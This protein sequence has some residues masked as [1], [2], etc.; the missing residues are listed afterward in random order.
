MHA[1]HT[2]RCQLEELF[3]ELPESINEQIEQADR[4]TLDT[5]LAQVP[6]TTSLATLFTQD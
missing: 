3:G 1:R 5:W 6:K 4:T 2:L